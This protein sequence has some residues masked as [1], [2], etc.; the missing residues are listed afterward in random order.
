[1][2]H[3][4][5]VFQSAARRA[6]AVVPLHYR[7][8]RHHIPDAGCEGAR[9][10]R[11]HR[12]RP[13]RGRGNV[14]HRSPR[15]GARPLCVQGLV[16]ARGV[17]APPSQQQPRR[18]ATTTASTTSTSATTSTSVATTPRAGGCGGSARRASPRR[19][20]T[21]CAHQPKLH[22]KAGAAGGG[23]GGGAR[24]QVAHVG[25]HSRAVRSAH[26]AC[27]N[28]VRRAPAPKTRLSTEPRR[29]GDQ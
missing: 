27:C 11:H 6:P 15:C 10:A 8:G 7:S 1:M 29:L 2:R 3:R 18:P 21:A 16:R 22:W 9:L 4:A 24:T 20:R 28:F 12:Q 17:R 13:I 19:Q 14:Q 26:E 5:P 25:L 23:C